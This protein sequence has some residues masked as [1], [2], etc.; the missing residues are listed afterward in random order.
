MLSHWNDSDAAR[1]A[2]PL[3]LRVYTSRLLGREPS[4]VLQ[5]GGNTSVKASAPNLFGEPEQLLYIKGS[6]W[7]LK[8]I[9]PAGFAP[10]RLDALQRMA[11][12]PALSDAEMVRAQRSAMTDPSAPTPSVEAILHAIIPFP[13]VDH[14][15]ADAVVAISNTP[16]GERR[17]REVYGD[18]VLVVPYVM[19]GFVLAR[20]VRELTRDL[21]W[22]RFEG[23]VLLNHGIFSF[24]ASARESYERMITLVTKAEEYL[25]AHG[26]RTAGDADYAEG[27]DCAEKAA[28][29]DVELLGELAALRRAVGNAGGKALVARLERSAAAV[30]FS[31][32]PDVAEI[33]GRG[34]LTP[35][36]VIRTKPLPMV[37]WEE[38]GGRWEEEIA[39]Y[40]SRYRDY[41]AR[42]ATAELSCLD[43][44]PRW[45][46]WKGRG[47]VTFG[48]SAKDAAV[49]ADIARHTSR[50]IEWAEPLGGW[51]A[52]PEREQFAV[53]YWE[54]EQAKL[55]Q[56][57]GTRPP[58]AGRV[59]LVTGAASGIGR[60]CAEAL[61][62]QGAAVLGT[63]INPA[64]EQLFQKDGLAGFVADA[65]D[66]A[67]VER[68]VRECVA[69][70][71]GI[72]ILVSNAGFF[73][74]SQRIGEIDPTIWEQSLALNLTSHLSLLQSAV[75]YL[76]LGFEPCVVIIGSKNVPA[77]GPGAAAYS[78][79]KA[80]LTQFGRV[81]AL[82]LGKEG[83]RVNTLHPHLVIDTAVWTPEVLA[84]RA[85]NY[86]M[87]GEQYIRNNLLGVEITT[88]DVANAVVALAGS[89]FSKTTGAQIPIDGGSD[90]VV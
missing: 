30:S 76:R 1:C 17:I 59:A 11:E 15:H 7:D 52:L 16:D 69:R 8:T 29:L 19:P 67:A 18:G 81:A 14:T 64:I 89:T 41:F 40:A 26:A 20:R 51:Q 80:G 12:L 72:D 47:F 35:D 38:G 57:G 6:G 62:A 33:A 31:K 3:E 87:T 54:L 5:G 9:E 88:A 10:V 49:V 48:A 24:G 84:D 2:N 34:P 58:L 79:A 37:I 4:L 70:F 86:G 53:E 82:E 39:G 21:D 25:V 56:Q 63:D 83:I 22:K 27:A 55:K 36:H 66:R 13:F 46:I 60:A 28:Q 68:S 32:R 85:K 42:H 50:A 77:P 23:I 45:V 75:P 65:T 90:R 43:P 71:G 44:A 74:P 78:A 73:S 61:H